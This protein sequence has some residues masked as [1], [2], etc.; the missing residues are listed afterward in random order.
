MEMY[1]ISFE[2][3]WLN[4]C[5]FLPIGPYDFDKYLIIINK[6]RNN[7]FDFSQEKNYFIDLMQ[8]ITTVIYLNK[9]KYCDGVCAGDYDENNNYE[10]IPELNCCYNINKYLKSYL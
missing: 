8:I 1:F 9:Y 6:I 2:Q 3:I 5:N 10:N 7:D 4:Y